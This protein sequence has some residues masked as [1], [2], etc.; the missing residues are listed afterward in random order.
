MLDFSFAPGCLILSP[1]RNRLCVTG[2]MVNL[3]PDQD[4]VGYRV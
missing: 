4:L 3:H 1:D 2:C